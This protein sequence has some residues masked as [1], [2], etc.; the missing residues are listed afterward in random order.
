MN[1]T[2]PSPPWYAPWRRA[3]HTVSP[4]DDPAGLGT[5]FGLELCTD[6]EPAHAAREAP[7]PVDGGWLQRLAARL[8]G[9]P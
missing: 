5:A 3:G 7:L 1:S 4:D 8:H 9:V 2:A 6:P